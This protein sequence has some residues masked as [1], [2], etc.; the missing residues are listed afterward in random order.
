MAECSLPA[1][2]KI[3]AGKTWPAPSSPKRPRNFR[4]YRW[5]PDDGKNPAVDTYPL[6]LAECGPMVLDALIKIKNEIKGD[7]RIY[8]LP[9]MPVVKDLVPDLTHVYAQYRSIQPWLQTESTAP[10]DKEWPQSIEEREKLDGL[11]E[12]ILDRKS[13]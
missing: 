9:H 4:V 12:C 6:D 5:S 11:W 2:S 8:P 3:G 1:N 10:P 7:V 13:T